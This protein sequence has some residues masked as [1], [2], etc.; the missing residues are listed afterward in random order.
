[1][2]RAATYTV[3]RDPQSHDV[4]DV[5]LIVD[6]E[7]PEAGHPHP[8]AAHVAGHLLQRPHAALVAARPDAAGPPVA[9]GRAVLVGRHPGEAPPLHHAL[10]T[11]P[12]AEMGKP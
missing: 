10:E 7:H 4:E 2:L 1:M 6:P 3:S 11:A 12:H 8:V 5:L 9:L